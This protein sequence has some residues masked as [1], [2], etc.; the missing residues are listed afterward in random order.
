[1]IAP[2]STR[3]CTSS[4]SSSDPY[5]YLFDRQ[6]WLARFVPGDR[7]YTEFSTFAFT[8]DIPARVIGNTAL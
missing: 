5:G 6:E 7:H 8:A 2:S 4:S 1:M 3:S